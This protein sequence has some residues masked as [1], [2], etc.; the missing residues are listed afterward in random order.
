M[1]I[2]EKKTSEMKEKKRKTNSICQENDNLIF[3]FK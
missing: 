3:F 1:E 2:K